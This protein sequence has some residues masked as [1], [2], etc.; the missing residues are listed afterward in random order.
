MFGLGCSRSGDAYA[1]GLFF[2]LFLKYTWAVGHCRFGFGP[3]SGRV[4][5]GGWA[6]R[7]LSARFGW[8]AVRVLLCL[9]TGACLKRSCLNRSGGAQKMDENERK[10][11]SLKRSCL[12]RSPPRV[13]KGMIFLFFFSRMD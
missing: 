10:K 6:V 5:L 3:V 9:P 8:L 12:N 13:W 11:E 4:L 2:V 7:V 1:S